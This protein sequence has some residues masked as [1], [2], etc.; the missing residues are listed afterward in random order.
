MPCDCMS[1]QLPIRRLGIGEWSADSKLVG[2]T[3]DIR[4]IRWRTHSAYPLE[5]ARS[6]EGSIPRRLVILSLMFAV[7]AAVHLPSAP[8]G[9]ALTRLPILLSHLLAGIVSAANPPPDA[10]LIDD[11]R[12]ALS[13]SSRGSR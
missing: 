1:R 11:G 9:A 12:F 7:I 8:T 3:G 10:A 5:F 2:A 4:G 6:A 13:I